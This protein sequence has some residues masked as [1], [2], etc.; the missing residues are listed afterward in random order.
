MTADTVSTPLLPGGDL[1]AASFDR[2]VMALADRGGASGMV[3]ARWADVCAE[4]SARWI[5][6][7][8]PIPGSGEPREQHRIVRVARLDDR[9]AVAEAAARRSLQNPDILLI[10]E[11]NGRTVVQAA[12]AKFSV[13]TARAKQVSAQ[14]VAGLLTLDDLLSDLTDLTGPLGDDP[15]LV[16][17]L[18]LCPD[19]PLTRLML[20]RRWGIVKTTVRAEQVAI[21]PA[22][23]RPFF[24]PLEGASLMP[25]LASVDALPLSIDDSLLA[26]LYYF[27]LGRAAVGCWLDATGPLLPLG[28]KD[29]PAVD[30]PAVLAETERRV[31]RAR[32]AWDLVLTWDADVQPIRAQRA[33]VDQVTA[34]PIVNRDL[35][36]RIA[37]TAARAG[38]GEGPSVNKVRRRLGAWYRSQIRERAGPLPPPVDDFARTL[39]DLGRIAASLSPALEVETRRVIAELIEQ[40]GNGATEEPLPAASA[41]PVP[42]SGT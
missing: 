18:F 26:G 27:R 11:R 32:S 21:L 36:E 42:I 35:R 1:V 23:S 22:P 5:G 40:G 9:P 37:R 19:F 12:D 3:G 7:A 30:E 38:L 25:P 15:D 41:T 4:H 14:V 31:D 17:G 6:K 29:R 8:F 16:D 13:E 24:A 34:L 39:Q 28:E 33:A 20:R 2:Q 10:G